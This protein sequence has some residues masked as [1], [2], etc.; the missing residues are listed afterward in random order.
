L[1]V[2]AVML[3]GGRAIDRPQVE[4]LDREALGL[5]AAEHLP[6]ET[7][8]DTVRLHDQQRRFGRHRRVSVAVTPRW[9]GAGGARPYY[10]APLE[11]GGERWRSRQGCSYRTWE[12]MSGD[13]T[14][15]SRDRRCTSSCTT[16][17]CGRG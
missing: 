3:L 12:P 8:P 9:I 17:R 15:T 2:L 5:D 13:P 11:S 10:R 7:A 14:P 4:L 1:P 16:D 6:D